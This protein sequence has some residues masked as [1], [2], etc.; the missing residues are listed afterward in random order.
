MSIRYPEKLHWSGDFHANLLVFWDRTN[1]D[2]FSRVSSKAISQHIYGKVMW[3]KLIARTLLDAWFKADSRHRLGHYLMGLKEFPIL[4]SMEETPTGLPL[5]AN[6]NQWVRSF[7][8][9]VSSTNLKRSHQ[10]DTRNSLSQL[11]LKLL[12][13]LNCTCLLPVYSNWSGITF[14]KVMIWCYEISFIKE[15]TVSFLAIF[16]GDHS[17]LPFNR[18]SLW[19]M[20][21]SWP[22]SPTLWHQEAWST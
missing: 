22:R 14:F 21:V 5:L 10:I 15:L 8:K 19:I 6:L 16:L 1:T 7:D 4:R 12:W 18:Q 17:F 2:G 9:V 20:R 11:S 13:R 3:S